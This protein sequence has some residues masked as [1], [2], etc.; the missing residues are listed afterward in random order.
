MLIGSVETTIA[1]VFAIVVLGPIVAERFRVPG[2][3]GLIAGGM[4]F[5]PYAIDWL[6]SGGLV[7]EL[8]SI[9]ILFLMFLAGLSFDIQS[10]RRNRSTAVLYGLTG[11][12]IPFVLT[13]VVVTT[14]PGIE[15]LGA[16]LVGAMWASNT[17]VAYPEVQ[18][19]GLQGTRSV[20]AAVSAGVV[21]DLLSLTVMAFVTSTAIIE[22]DPPDIPV[23]G[24][25]S[26][27]L[28]TEGVRPTTPDPTLPLWAG[29][30]LLVVVCL[31][32]LPRVADWFF[33]R[34]GRDRPQ[35]VVFMIALMGTGSTFAL[36]GGMEGLIG[37]FLAGLGLNRLVP[38]R[39]LLMER[40]D[41]VG[42]TLF[43]PVFLISI[44]LQIDPAVLVDPET[45]GLGLLFSG[46]VV[47]GKTAA[48]VISGLARNL[49][50]DEV[51]LMSSLS[52]GQAAST[53][54]IAEVGNQLGMFDQD[55]VN[56]AVLAIVV[57][58]F[59]T[60]YATRFF[61]SRVPPPD[62]ERP[63]L[64]HSIL[65]DT[66]QIGSDVE[67]LLSFAGALARADDGV[68]VPY[69]IAGEPGGHTVARTGVD[70]VIASASALGLDVDGVVRVD[71]SFVDTTVNLVAELG[72]SLVVL[73]WSGPRFAVDY[74]FGNDIDGV[75]AANPV[76]TVAAHLL[77]PW[78]R[79]V[80]WLGD[81]RAAWQ[82]DDARLALDVA[83]RLGTAR[84][85]P[86]T[87]LCRDPADADAIGPG[88]E[89]VVVITDADAQHD[90][91]DASHPGDL[92]V[93]PAHVVRDLAPLRALR[94]ARRLHDTN[95][96]IVAGPYRLTISN[97]PS[98]QG[99]VSPVTVVP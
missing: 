78:D 71:D 42:G 72:S 67:T 61:A 40:L 27:R 2:I 45:I 85:T 39:G 34:V 53:L 56:A 9:G 31:W 19:A 86:V 88:D 62:A 38:T 11:F 14:A 41:F 80:I 29:L 49:S 60:S 81:E 4:L 83:K 73:D 76:P 24:E 92:L 96:A 64:G 84:P 8:G 98:R 90:A 82:R 30:P 1:I 94:L 52:F 3:V 21:A 6:Q 7:D 22:I 26:E 15:F 93:V 20:G 28:V 59:I 43:V 44:G 77:R 25:L 63:P 54:A 66:R 70:G 47:V 18:S 12:I 74:V 79:L 16:L 58:A 65:L 33:V 5:G 99:V 48:A 36:L 75:G 68:V 55:V 57:T 17:L 91:L 89:G 37:A 51:G 10:F 87:V 32:L 13:V 69:A 35:R 46:F 23:I 50:W 95:L 97:G